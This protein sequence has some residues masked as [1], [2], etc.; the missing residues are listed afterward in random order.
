MPWGPASFR[1]TPPAP[2][3]ARSGNRRSASTSPTGR[4]TSW[5]SGDRSRRRTRAGRR[6]SVRA[7]CWSWVRTA[8]RNFPRSPLPPAG[9][10]GRRGGARVGVGCE[11]WGWPPYH[12]GRWAFAVN[13]G[14][15]WVPP[16]RGDVFWA[17]GYVGWVRTGDH[18]AWV[19]LAPREVYYGRG[20][21]GRDGRNITKGEIHK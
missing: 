12:Y 3:S 4:R 5:C 15:L 16:A 1:A 2:P 21:Y 9:R 11:P 17:P 20:N 7:A 13:I 14:W 6:R 10:R 8:T 18:V 19:P